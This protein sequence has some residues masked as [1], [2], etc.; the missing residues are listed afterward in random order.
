MFS[1]TVNELNT[2]SI[3]T[4]KDTTLY[5][6][7]YSWKVAGNTW[8]GNLP[9]QQLLTLAKWWG[10]IGKRVRILSGEKTYKFRL[11]LE[12]FIDKNTHFCNVFP[13][14]FAHFVYPFFLV[15]FDVS[16][17]FEVAFLTP[18][19]TV[20]FCFWSEHLHKINTK[21]GL[22]ILIFRYT[23]ASMRRI[24]LQLPVYSSYSRYNVCFS[25]LFTQS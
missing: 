20:K 25:L 11:F 19:A 23:A 22:F 1:K 24:C 21:I 3:K 8:H 9:R 13:I 7:A 15:T 5:L 14:S 16:R 4:R 6:T 18:G 12:I 10:S 2:V 17:L